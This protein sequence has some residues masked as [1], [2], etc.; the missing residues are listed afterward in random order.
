M[1]FWKKRFWLGSLRCF[2]RKWSTN[3]YLRLNAIA[4][5][6]RSNEKVIPPIFSRSC[7]YVSLQKR[8][9]MVEKSQKTALSWRKRAT[10]ITMLEATLLIGSR[11]CTKFKISQSAAANVRLD[12]TVWFWWSKSEENQLFFEWQKFNNLIWLLHKPYYR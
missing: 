2:P 9:K 1:A 5:A 12:I 11:L 7:F 8:R 10:L 4:C 3:L 6:S